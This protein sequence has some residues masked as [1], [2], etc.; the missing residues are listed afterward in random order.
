MATF[1]GNDLG[2]VEEWE[3]TAAPKERQITGY[4]AVDG[5]EVTDLG[6]RGGRTMIRGVL[7]FDL[8]DYDSSILALAAYKQVLRNYQ[9]DGGTYVFLDDEDTEWDDAILELF[10]PYG[11]RRNFN[12]TGIL[13]KYEM[14][15]LHTGD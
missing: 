10:K 2:L 1:D 7:Y 5:L 8:G 15:L 6:A 4:P 13:Q 11:P 3:T 14:E 12:G 9:I